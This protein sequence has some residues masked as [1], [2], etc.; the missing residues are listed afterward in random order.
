MLK[1]KRSL[2]VISGAMAVSGAGTALVGATPPQN[3]QKNGG[4]NSADNAK[5]SKVE[6]ILKGALVTLIAA[7]GIGAVALTV[8]AFVHKSIAKSDLQEIIDSYEN[9][10]KELGNRG[11]SVIEKKINKLKDEIK[12]I[13]IVGENGK[14]IDSENISIE[15]LDTK[16]QK[17]KE[18]NGDAFKEYDAEMQSNKKDKESFLKLLEDN[19]EDLKV[20]GFDVENFKNRE[21]FTVDNILNLF[22]KVSEEAGLTSYEYIDIKCGKL[23]ESFLS[24]HQNFLL[25][26]NL[27]KKR[28]SLKYFYP[29]V[30]RGKGDILTFI[31]TEEL[32]N[33][34]KKCKDDLDEHKKLC[35]EVFNNR[36]MVSFID[37]ERVVKSKE[38]FFEEGFFKK[39]DDYEKLLK[40]KKELKKKLSLLEEIEQKESELKKEEKFY[41]EAIKRKKSLENSFWNFGK[42]FFKLHGNDDLRINIY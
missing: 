2:Q 31:K 32:R 10:R 26:N 25:D 39:R 11:K 27:E 38:H 35:E 18:K 24:K 7:T 5:D 14:K 22:L 15:E 1:G 36:I 8:W 19:K 33:E 42:D 30:K 23:L 34:I 29:Y 40:K 37:L 3:M 17:F 41:E 21:D 13:N 4:A 9:K 28:F 6:K 12:S 16:Y 20:L